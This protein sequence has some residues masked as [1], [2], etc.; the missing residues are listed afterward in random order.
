MRKKTVLPVKEVTLPQLKKLTPYLEKAK[1]TPKQRKFAYYWVQN[2]GDVLDAAE[3]A[4][5]QTKHVGDEYI[6]RMRVQGQ[7]TLRKQAVQHAIQE[8]IS[9]EIMITEKQLEY[10]IYKK[11]M[12]IADYDILDFL[13]PNG[14]VKKDLSSI[15]EPLRRCIKKVEVKY[16][17]KGGMEYTRIV[18]IEIMNREWAIE[19]LMEYIQMIKKD[20]TNINVVSEETK[21]QLLNIL[22]GK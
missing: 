5:Y 15:P 2:G 17:K 1:L 4:G 13:E 16:A 9:H 20:V 12:L 22:R 21:I 7:Q 14:R 11:L 8:I 3:K 6:E 10:N 18:S 19:K